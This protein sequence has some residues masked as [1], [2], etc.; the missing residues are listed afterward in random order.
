MSINATVG[1]MFQ[2]ILL[3]WVFDRPRK[4]KENMVKI[5]EACDQMNQRT[6]TDAV[7]FIFVLSH[8]T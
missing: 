6:H 8:A 4:D 5:L 3:E 2:V 7:N 1:K